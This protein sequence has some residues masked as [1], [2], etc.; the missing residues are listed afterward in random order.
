MKSLLRSVV[1]LAALFAAQGKS[2]ADPERT[3]V[4]YDLTLNMSKLQPLRVYLG[5][6]GTE[7]D[8]RRANRHG[9]RG[10]ATTF[11]RILGRGACVCV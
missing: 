3:L 2:A 8:G 5:L 10:E 6:P 9:A 4:Q 1:C 11:I 7:G